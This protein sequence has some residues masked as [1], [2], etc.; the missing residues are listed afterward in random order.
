MKNWIFKEDSSAP[1]DPKA[2]RQRAMLLSLPF[3]LMGV[4]AIVSFLHDEIGSGFRMESKMARGSL[5]A[6]VVCGGLIALIFGISA[7]KHAIQ[8]STLKSDDEKPWLKR[9]DWA[10]GRIASSL[11]KPVLLLWIFVAFWCGISGAISLFIIPPGNHGALIALMVIS[12]ALIFFQNRNPLH[13]LRRSRRARWHTP[14]QDYGQG[15]IKA[16]ARITPAFALCPLHDNR[17]V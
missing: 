7:K 2:A 6:A 16:T 4:V 1:S 3:A 17:Q 9:K 5:F 13:R 8:T 10:S 14:R 12:L 15:K 11:R